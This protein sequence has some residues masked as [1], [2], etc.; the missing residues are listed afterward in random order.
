MLSL[1]VIFIKY[2]FNKKPKIAITGLNPHCESNFRSSEED[3]IIIP[4][5]KKIKIK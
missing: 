4:A 3:K 1:L 2:N 5:I